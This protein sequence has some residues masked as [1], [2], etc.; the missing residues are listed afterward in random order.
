MKK[1]I[2]IPLI[3]V[4]LL[5][6]AV[7]I[8][9]GLYITDGLPEN[10]TYAISRFLNKIDTGFTPDQQNPL[11]ENIA[12]AQIEAKMPENIHAV[13]LDLAAELTADPSS[14]SYG[15]LVAEIVYDFNYY[16]NFLT[17]T[18]FVVPDLS[19]KYE[20]FTDAYGNRVDVLR[21]CLNYSESAGY[22]KV[23]VVNDE[24]LYNNGA[25]SFDQI[26]YYLS[27]YPFNA[28]V[29]SSEAL[30]EAGTVG[31]CVSFISENIK[32]VFG[33][34]ICFG[35]EIPAKTA[36]KG[37]AEQTTGI[38]QS[39]CLEFAVVEGGAMTDP[40]MPFGSVLS[41]W[42]AL[43]GTY[44]DITFYCKHRND[45][46]CTNQSQWNNY[47]EICDQVRFLWDCENI[48]GS[49]F[50]N[51][52]A[53]K[54]NKNSSS[55]RLSYLLYDGEYS[56]LAIESIQIEEQS[57]SVLFTGKAAE[58]HKTLCNGS[59]IGAGPSFTFRAPLTAGSNTFRFFSCGKNL[60]Y[61]IFGNTRIIYSFSPTADLSVLSNETVAVS[62]VC[63]SDAIVQCAING[64]V[65]QMTKTGA[66]NTDGIPSGYS[67]F[68]CGIKFSVEANADVN[69]GS[70]R[71][72]ASVGDSTETVTAAGITVMKNDRAGL[73]NNIIGYY[74]NL[75]DASE[76]HMDRFTYSDQVSPYHDNGLGTA[77]LCRIINDETETIGEIGEKDTYHA[78]SST[79]TAGT[80]DYVTG[81]EISDAGFLRY[82]LGS[83]LTVYGVNCELIANGYKM[84]NNR[85]IADRVDDTSP[86]S[87]DLVF[88]IDWFSPVTVKCKPLKYWNGYSQ[89]SYNVSSFDAEY[90]E[91]KFYHATEFY[92]SS[93]LQFGENSVFSR[94]ELYSAGDDNLILRVYLKKPGQFYG[95]RIYR[96]DANQLV[97]SCKKR[98]NGS[99]QGKMIMLDAG[100]GGLSMTGTAVAD[101]SV[102]E[103]IVT[104]AIASK[105]KEMLESKGAT[106]IMTRTMDTPIT[107]DDRCV[108]LR[109]YNPDIF[110]S[111]HCDG[112]ENETDAGT[113]SFYFRPY[114]MPLA[115]AINKELSTVYKTHIYAP[116]DTNYPKVDKSIKFYPFYVTRMNDCPSVLVETGF[117]T[118]P[119]EGMILGNDNTQ[120]WLAFG[121]TN[122]IESYLSANYQ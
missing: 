24:M 57:N 122:G 120:Y 54:K 116:T 80:I 70:I 87:T 14:G 10:I 44:P 69:L 38:L 11:P 71:I 68:S 58:G 76:E 47:V 66:A 22:T 42:N 49:V 37:A 21:E 64:N 100:H 6:S 81:M 96:N 73:F 15:D 29:L 23:L 92:N 109:K 118:N 30:F 105:A 33:G 45:L 32:K 113:H 94:T 31:N 59:V 62:A 77:L 82:K 110:V 16:K 121:I 17:D 65:Y 56:D 60:T 112:T 55:L 34:A 5:L 85:I 98:L 72:T 91:I 117:M 106:V 2:L 101:N 35:V 3:A 102:S 40:A 1:K 18:I 119:V 88:N 52:T 108:L 78:D 48:S 25:L 20:N 26:Q 79:L 12:V 95:F 19:G 89:Y 74:T 84:P 46:V 61:R 86:S 41:Y 43:A 75:R 8:T 27:N 103:K 50:Y 13:T 111:I 97:V 9:A 4:F 99:L 83:G 114:S 51:T 36:V 39:G 107:L 115:D 63:L 53:L 90:I 104:L 7:V 67:T 93:V 28:A